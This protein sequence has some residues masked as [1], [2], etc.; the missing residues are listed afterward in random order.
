MSS[1]IAEQL[2]ALEQEGVAVY[3]G[4]LQQ[5][6]HV[7]APLI[8]IVCDNPRA[9]ELLNHLGSS[10]IKYCCICMVR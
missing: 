8:C 6:V 2:T 4:F 7:I 3:D 9:S 10:A 1:P 5:M